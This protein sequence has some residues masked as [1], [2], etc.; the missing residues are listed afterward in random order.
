[1]PAVTGRTETGKEQ[2][3]R[4]RERYPNAGERNAII[5]VKN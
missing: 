2:N 5:I 4:T 1:M 3:N